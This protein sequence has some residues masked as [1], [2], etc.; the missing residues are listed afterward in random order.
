MNELYRYVSL[1][2]YF[3]SYVETSLCFF[4]MSDNLWTYL[5]R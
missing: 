1:E 5:E 2:S 4:N 3:G